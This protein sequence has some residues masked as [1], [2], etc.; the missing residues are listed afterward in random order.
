MRP[1]RAS[2]ALEKEAISDILDA[3]PDK[4]DK[5]DMMMLPPPGPAA[6]RCGRF[7]ASEE[8]KDWT[9]DMGAGAADE[10]E[11]LA[12]LPRSGAAA[13]SWPRDD[14]ETPTGP[15]YIYS[16]ALVVLQHPGIVVF[17]R[18]AVE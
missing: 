15:A 9:L 4:V 7:E 13:S 12:M 14:M 2:L 1:S 18:T 3:A 5:D 11:E 8:D 16:I 10:E 6:W 17:Q